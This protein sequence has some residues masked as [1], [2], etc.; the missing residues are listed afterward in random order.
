MSCI[1]LHVGTETFYSDV[2]LCVNF[3]R[4]WLKRKGML[5]FFVK[6]TLSDKNTLLALNNGTSGD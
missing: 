2:Q 4:L 3:R 1:K 5:T 6:K